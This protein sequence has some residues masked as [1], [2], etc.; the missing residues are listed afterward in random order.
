MTDILTE[1]QKG[2]LGFITGFVQ[3]RGYPPTLREIGRHFRIPST[4]SVSYHLRALEGR[5]LLKRNRGSSRGLELL[6]SPFRLPVLG[7]VGAGG[8][9]LAQEDVEGHIA[10]DKQMARGAHF[11]LRVRGD[12]MTGAG[13]FEGDLVQVRRQPTAQ[14]GETVVA[15]VHDA[16]VVKHLRRRGDHHFLESAHPDYPPITKDF[17]LIGKVVGLVRRF[18][19]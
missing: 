18:E 4:G 19:R 10:V 12:S 14:T 17:E 16:A 13:I 9:V 8:H 7:R 3:E 15:L 2:I 6:E 1:T 11:F 5:G